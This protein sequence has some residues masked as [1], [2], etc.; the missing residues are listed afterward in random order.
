MSGART[1]LAMGGGG[2]TMEP[3]N[4]VLDDFVLGLA[5]AREPRILFLPT[6]SGDPAAQI[7]AFHDRFADRACTAAHLSLFRLHGL[8]RPLRE[9]VLEQDV[10]YIGGGSMRKLLAIWRAH[11]LDTLLTEAWERGVVLAGLSAGAM[12]WFEG[13]ITRSNS[14]GPPSKWVARCCVRACRHF[15][16]SRALSASNP[17]WSGRRRR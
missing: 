14:T 17:P 13:G 16:Y 4:P 11:G 7:A 9:I 6:A 5:A 10:V 12:C 2:F 3:D 1:I 8:R 15:A